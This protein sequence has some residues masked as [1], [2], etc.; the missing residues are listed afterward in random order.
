M[1]D[2]DIKNESWYIKKLVAMVNN[3]EVYKPKYQ[4]KR[5]WDLFK[6]KE[7]IP[8]DK[9][10]IEFL[11]DTSNSVHPITFGNDESKLSNID[12]NNR[13][14]AI[15]HFLQEPLVLF[16]ERLV[17]LHETI[18]K[19]INKTTANVVESI[20]KNI[21]YDNLMTFKYHKYFVDNDFK[22]L[23][24]NHL[25][26]VRDELEPYFDD[27]INSM[28][29][30]NKDRFDND[31]KINATIFYGYTDEE[32]SEV[33]GKIN[34]YY[35]GLTEQE[36]LAS[37]L[38]NMIN[39]TINNKT[40]ECKIKQQL[41][42]YYDERQQDEIL[43]CYIYDETTDV[44]NAFD[45]MVGF[46]NY[47][48]SKCSLIHKTE[49]DGLSL[50]FKLFKTLYKGNFNKTINTNNINEFIEL[51]STT[52][53]VLQKIEK[54]IFMPNFTNGKN[55]I[56]D[57]A[58]KKLNSL[59]KNNMYLI[60]ISIIGYIKSN[61]PEKEILKSIETCILY[62]YFVHGIDNKD[63]RDL[64]K[65]NDGILYEAGGCFIDNKAKD[66]LKTPCL[67]SNKITDTVM[68][69]LLNYLIDENIKDKAYE[70]R[71]NGKDKKDKRRTRK[72]HEK[73]LLYYYFI[74]KVPTQFLNNIFWVEHTC[75]F[76]C[77][78]ENNIDID[79]LGNIFPILET[80]NRERS[81]KHIKEYKKIDKQNFLT[82]IDVVP[83]IF[84]Y[85]EVVSHT[86]RKPRIYN[87]EKY[88]EM[89]SNNEQIFIECLIQYL[90]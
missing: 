68:T 58:N 1:T 53:N 48:N 3:R 44:M 67:V 56:F 13:I 49:N 50:F 89:C 17:K 74:C 10:Y 29:V 43:N 75:P 78:W 28:K 59:K 12:G 22:E 88:N 35:S 40:L 23:Y 71:P 87:S 9:N 77:S 4:R 61:T 63:K 73:V 69:E 57:T 11:Y 21:S 2:K 42:K 14:N 72:V 62:H 37:A 26:L 47:S 41:Q 30:N 16:P 80:L 76:S 18:T 15:I 90:F 65:L 51:I 25:K 20:M 54:T 38:Y 45:F 5:K 55:K 46:Q 60:M 7:N 66:Y 39:F 79:R 27:L 31:V 8:N 36:A 82:Y 86:S 64:Y 70:L 19:Y 81:N 32:L 6:K 52:I 24:N 84:H 85:D 83:D 34:K 33:F